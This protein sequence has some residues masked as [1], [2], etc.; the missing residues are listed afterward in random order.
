MT[1]E[2]HKA[3]LDE[4]IKTRVMGVPFQ[5]QK[6]HAKETYGPACLAAAN[7]AGITRR[8]LDAAA[9]GKLL[10]YLEAAIEDKWDTIVR[11][12]PPKL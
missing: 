8:E 3:W 9:G 11:T 1:G 2:Q 6:R 10:P 4:W 7:A 12:T 5:E